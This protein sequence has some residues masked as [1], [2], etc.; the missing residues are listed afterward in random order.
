MATTLTYPAAQQA[1]YAGQGYADYI[2]QSMDE[3]MRLG[4]YSH[5]YAMSV[6]LGELLTGNDGD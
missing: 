4:H 5:E 2:Q 1:L 3:R 6:D